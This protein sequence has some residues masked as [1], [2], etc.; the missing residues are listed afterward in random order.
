MNSVDHNDIFDHMYGT[1][2]GNLLNNYEGHLES[3]SMAL[4]L[5]FL[6]GLVSF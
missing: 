4:Y 2:P 6:P 3:S 5:S 1:D